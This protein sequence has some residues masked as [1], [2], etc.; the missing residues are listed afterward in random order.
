MKTQHDR[1]RLLILTHSRLLAHI[2]A[3]TNALFVVATRRWGVSLNSVARSRYS[4]RV[5]KNAYSSADV[6]QW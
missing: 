4:H 2:E 3:F 5:G 6:A 1:L